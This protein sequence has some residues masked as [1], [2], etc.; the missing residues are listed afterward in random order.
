M[1]KMRGNLIY[2]ETTYNVKSRALHAQFIVEGNCRSAALC[3]LSAL[4]FL[5]AHR[6]LAVSNLSTYSRRPWKQKHAANYLFNQREV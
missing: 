6:E 5:R 4:T 3:S 2:V 1:T